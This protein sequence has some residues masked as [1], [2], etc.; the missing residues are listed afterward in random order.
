[1]ATPVVIIITIT[2]IT[3]IIIN[4]F[5]VMFPELSRQSRD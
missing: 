3:N 1:M 4:M 5:K 2:I